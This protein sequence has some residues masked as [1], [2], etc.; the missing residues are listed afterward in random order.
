MSRCPT[1]KKPATKDGNKVFPFCCE[2]CQLVD[3]G[4]W[5][6]E[7]YRIPVETEATPPPPGGDPET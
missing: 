7:D 5:L 6:D 1:C 3:L 4:R 2:R